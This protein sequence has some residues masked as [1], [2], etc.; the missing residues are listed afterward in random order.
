VPPTPEDRRAQT[1]RIAA[2]LRELGA[3]A[4][5]L[6]VRATTGHALRQ[7][8]GTRSAGAATPTARAVAA[9][10]APEAAAAPPP[11]TSG[12]DAAARI[13]AARERLR[14]RIAA[15][16]DEAQGR[17]PSEGGPEA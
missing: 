13:D 6:A 3:D 17:E 7:P 14:S 4:L 11:A 16:A 1:R 9:V 5:A 10:H 15:P 8:V 12:E 2:A